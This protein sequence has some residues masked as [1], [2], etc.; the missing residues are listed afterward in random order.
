MPHRFD[1][2][3]PGHESA[4]PHYV[5]FDAADG[6]SYIVRREHQDPVFGW[7]WTA[8]VWVDTSDPGHPQY[9]MGFW[10]EVA[11]CYDNGAVDHVRKRLVGE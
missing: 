8:K 4:D 6:A 5:R 10:R 9:H 1:A 3:Q 2:L 7:K 11:W